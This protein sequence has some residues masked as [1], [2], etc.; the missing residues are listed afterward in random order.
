MLKNIDDNENKLNAK[1]FTTNKV[2]SNRAVLSNIG[3]IQAT[4]L[5]SGKNFKN[6]VT[7]NYKIILI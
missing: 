1:R 7:L 4:N 3:N 2:T 6:K 5:R